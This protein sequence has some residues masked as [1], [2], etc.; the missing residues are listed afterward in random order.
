MTQKQEENSDYAEVFTFGYISSCLYFMICRLS[1]RREAIYHVSSDEYLSDSSSCTDNRSDLGLDDYNNYESNYESDNEEATRASTNITTTQSFQ[2]SLRQKKFNDKFSPKN[3]INAIRKILLSPPRDISDEKSSLEFLPIYSFLFPNDKGSSLYNAYDQDE[4]ENK[5]VIKIDQ[6]DQAPKFSVA[7]DISEVYGLPGIHEC[8]NGQKPLRVVIDI[9]VSKEDMKTASVK[10]Q[11]GL[12]IATSSNPSKCSYHILY[13]PA[14]IIDHYELKSLTELVYTITDEKFGKYIDKRL[15]GQNFNLRL[16]GLAKK[17]RVKRILQF[18]LDNRWNELDHVR[19]SDE[20]E[21]VFKCDPSI[22]EKIR[23]E[24]KKLSSLPSICKVK[25]LGFLRAFVKLP[26]WAKGY[27][28]GLTWK[29]GKTYI[30]KHLTIADDVNLLVLSTRHSYSNA[31]TTRLN[32]KSYFD[33]DGN[34]NLPDHK[35]VVCQIESLHHIANKCKCSK[36]CKCFPIKYDLWLDEII[37]I[38][39]QAQSHLARQSIEKLYKLIREARRI[40]VMDN[41][42]TDLNI[43]WIKTL[44]KN[45]PLSIIHNTFQPQRDWAKQMILLPFENRTSA[46][47]ICHLRK[48]VQGIVHALKTDFPELQIKKYHGKSDPVKKAHDFSNVEESWSNVD[49]VVYT[50][51]LKIGVSC[52]NPKFKWA[53]YL[54]N[55]YIE[56][57]ARMNQMLFPFMLEKFHSRRL[58]GWR[59]VDFLREAG[60]IISIIESSPKSNKN[61]LSQV[62]KAKCSVVKADEISDITNANILNHETAEF[63]ESKPRKTLEEMHSLDRHHIVDCYGISPES[64]T[65]N[66]IS[67]YGNYNHIKWFRAYKQLRDAGTNNKMAIE[68]ISRK[69]YREDRLTTATWAERYRICL[70]LLRICTPVRDIND[71][72]RYKADEVKTRM[73]FP[74]STSY[75]QGLVPKMARVFDNTDASRSANKLGLKTI[76][77]KLGLLNASLYATYGLKFKVIDKNHR[78]YHLVGSFDSKDAPRLPSYQTGEEI[79]WENGED[80]RYGYSKLPPDELID[81]FTSSSKVGNTQIT[82]DIQDIF[83]IC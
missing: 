73:G 3:L 64:L 76:R 39:A 7:D 10:G 52:T 43:E 75:L 20:P 80:T 77:A 31:V 50:N 72:I 68:A 37:S 30:L 13:A 49:L 36:K 47:L 59:I 34:T 51:T 48:D 1:S 63:L 21:E 2:Y 58:F 18:S 56:I 25:G 45:I 15:P 28:C 60:M 19:N 42:L 83:D 22:A 54:F 26:S 12:V 53:F 16:I 17:G 69:D 35:K 61:T 71:R 38:I 70:E 65:K 8:I 24:N 27:L 82:E 4:V 57:N 67:K 6:D 44:R 11:E 46:S 74:E 5:L 23:Q 32:L 41:D 9:D 40:I 78:H 29:T 55:S 33:I 79:Y 81:N 66:F 62:V 14:L